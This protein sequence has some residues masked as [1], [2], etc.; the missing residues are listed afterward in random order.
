MCGGHVLHERFFAGDPW[1]LG[2]L[3]AGRYPLKDEL[4]GRTWEFLERA[5]AWDG[6]WG[7]T[8]GAATS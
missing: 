7:G 3:A 5:R 4:K 1:R 8:S 6:R 2:A